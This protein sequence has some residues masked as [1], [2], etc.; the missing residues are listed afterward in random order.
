MKSTSV[1]TI[2]ILTSG[3]DA[4]GLNAAIRALC[5][6]GKQNYN[7]NFIGIRNGYKGLIENDTFKLDN[8]DFSKLISEGGTF[9]GTSRVKP[10]KN[11]VP[12]PKTGLLPVEAISETFKKNKLDALVCLGGNGTNTTASLL[13]EAGFNVIGL[14]KT[15]DNDIVGT[16]ETFGFRTAI[17]I[18]TNGIDAIRT[19]AKSHSRVMVVEIMG[20]KVGWLGL[21]SG[22][23]SAAD[24][25]L[26]P[27]IPYDIN[28]IGEFIKNRQKAGYNYSI[29]ACSEG[30]KNI[31]EGKMT[32]KEFKKAREHMSQ[33]I[34]F[35]VA[36]ELEAI[37]GIETRTSVLGYIQRGGSPSPYDK[38]LATQ[39]GTAAADFLANKD[40]GKLVA[41]NGGKI[42][43]VPLSTVASGVKS[44][45]MDDPMLLTARKL[46][47]CLGD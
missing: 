18:A 37:T 25:I 13:S 46:G 19:T 44:I 43:S 30:A 32:K 11:P 20:H 28:K 34:G 24:V 33:S 26:L 10:F 41:M 23:A 14:P 31:E 12:N 21:Y 29:I 22:I 5:I 36:K 2:G 45:P 35:R 7:M 9:L 27:E 42:E 15:I 40:F 4:P 3:G 38:V 47:I 17:D 8:L 16:D 1:K 39:I 6:S